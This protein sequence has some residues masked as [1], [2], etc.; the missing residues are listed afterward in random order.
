MTV[1]VPDAQGVNPPHHRERRGAVRRHGD[2]GGPEHEGLIPLVATTVEEVRRLGVRPG[3]D[4]ARH[5]HDVELEARGV[6]PHDLLLL[7]N[8]D[9]PSLVAAL[10]DA[11]LLVFDV[12]SS[13]PDF[14]EPA[15][16]VANVGIAAVA[17]VGVR[18]DEGPV[19]DFRRRRAL[20]VSHA[21]SRELLVLVGCQQGTDD[22]GGLIG[23][24]VQRVAREIGARILGDAAFGRCRPSAEVDSFDTHPLD[25]DCLTRRVGTKRGDRLAGGKKLAQ[26]VVE[27][28]GAR[29]GDGVI[30]CNPA[31]LLGDLAGRVEADQP[32]ESGPGEVLIDVVDLL[33]QCAHVLTP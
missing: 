27:R 13:D 30:G 22:G 25:V 6:Q 29:P 5:P 2:V 10:L 8:E 23:H 21:R 3:D 16:E 4:D 32:L 33:V 12:V 31:T 19:V 20:L 1:D 11:R 7:G 14:H 17:R 28:L 26:T 24:L 15:D 9:L 18:D